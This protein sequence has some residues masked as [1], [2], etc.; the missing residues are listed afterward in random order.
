MMEIFPYLV[1]ALFAAGVIYGVLRI[2]EK[3]EE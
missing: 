1:L 3:D 2:V